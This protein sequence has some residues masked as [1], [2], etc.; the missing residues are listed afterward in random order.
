MS[1]DVTLLLRA[2]SEGDEKAADQI[3]PLVYDELHRRAEAIFRRE[4]AGHTLQPTALINEAFA[5][6][7]VADVSWNDRV[8]FYALASR[9]MRRLLVNHAEASRAA[10]RG[11]DAIHVTL[12]DANVGSAEDEDIVQ[13]VDAL[14]DLEHHSARMSE[15][16]QLRYF[17]G[18]TGEEIASVTG[19]STATV[20]RELRFARAW[21][22]AQM[23]DDQ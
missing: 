16:I 13:L 2:W 22:K 5:K 19:L 18:L 6:L 4:R 1:A 21:L 14:D 9:M 17:G 7:L 23:Q 8:H 12:E 3:A 15:I 11:G 20:S 10:K